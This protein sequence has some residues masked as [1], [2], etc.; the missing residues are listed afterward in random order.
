MRI[1][2]IIETVFLSVNGNKPSTDNSIIRADIRAL[3]PAAINYALD[4]AYN[5][6]IRSEGDRDMPNEF[7]GYYEDIL[8]DRTG[9]RPFVPMTEGAVPLKGNQGIR[10]VFD[11]CDNYYAPLSDGDLATANFWADRGTGSKWYRRKKNTIELWNIL[12][13]AKRVS[14]AALTDIN[15]LS[16]E[17]EAPIQAGKEPMVIEMLSNLVRGKQTPYD[18]KI[19]SRDDVNAVPYK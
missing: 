9:K 14:Y 12:P 10:F 15:S 7:Y 13:T 4:A 19:D 1:G 2:I 18:N 11:D 17:D 3:L 6:E 8:V 5:D 16:D